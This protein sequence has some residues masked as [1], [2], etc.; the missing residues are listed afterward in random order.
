MRPGAA[1][2]LWAVEFPRLCAAAIFLVLALSVAA[3]PGLRF[4]SDPNRVFLSNSPL[5][6]AER[7]LRARFVPPTSDVALLVE[8]ASPFTANQIQ[9]ARNAALDLEFAEGVL[10]VASPFALRFPPWHP[11]FPEAPVIPLTIDAAEISD[12]LDRFKDL[13]TALP[14]FMTSSEMLIVV[15][16]ATE[17]QPT[18]AALPMLSTVAEDL[19][20]HG[21]TVSLTGADVVGLSITQGLTSD[22]VRINLLGAALVVLVVLVLLRDWRLSVLAVGPALM[23]PTATLGLSVA[24]GYPITVLNN[25]LPLLMLV[26]GVAN[27]LHLAVHFAQTQGDLRARI[28]DTAWV[29]APACVMTAVTTALAFVAMLVAPNAQ[30][31]EFAILG[32]VG[33]AATLALLLPGFGLLAWWL[34]PDPRT[35]AHAPGHWAARLGAFALKTPGRVTVAGLMALG[36]ATTGYATAQPW[37]PLHRNLPDNS[38]LIDINDNVAETFGGVFRTWVELPQGATWA[39]LTRVVKA[40]EDVAPEGS[41]LSES[42]V[43]RWLGDASVP[44]GE[45]ALTRLPPPL[46]DQLRDPKDGSLRFAVAMPEPMRSA[47]TLV[48]FDRIEAAAL[49]AGAARVLGLPA[50]MRHE[51]PA[52]IRQLSTGLLLACVTGAALVAAA[53]RRLSLFPMVLLAN[54]LPVLGVGATVH[55]LTGGFLTPPVVMS[56]TIAF[57]VA[58][59][60]SIHLLNRHQ[61]A[62]SQGAATPDAIRSAL[63]QAGGV[64][65]MTT[66]ILCAG[67][68]VTLLSGFPPVRLFGT[69]LGL[70]LLAALLADLLVLPAML[71]LGDRGA[72]T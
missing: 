13:D 58:V 14:L 49:D 38:P 28:A 20:A 6:Q 66:L 57:G 16:I 32:A 2:V 42:A 21:L 48:A 44:P 50:I 60:D 8:A 18:D 72:S 29:V 45:D 51:A 65:G 5:S 23:G 11:E 35:V 12:R 34:A 4:D 64:M 10:S 62:L 25:V 15:T 41:V 31:L 33:V 40:V 68:G 70:S 61:I 22:L 69:M 46:A 19:A 47:E 56:L 24:F 55:V 17:T 54:L 53:F 71:K 36:V 9:Q 39:D 43:A 52:L 26:L 27:G 59:D 30:V 1:L 7:D 3:L 63:T 37:F 67:L